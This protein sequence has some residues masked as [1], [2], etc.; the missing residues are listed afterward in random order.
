MQSPRKPDFENLL[1]VLRREAPSRP[2]LFEFIIDPNAM[3]PDLPVL[4]ESD[5]G[6]RLR[7]WIETYVAFPYDF[8]SLP[9]WLLNLLSF[10]KGER[11]H[12]ASISQNEGGLIVDEETFEAY[13]WPDPDAGDYDQVKD[14]AA[15][16]APGMKFVAFCP[17][18]VLEN[19]TEIVGFE[20][21]CFLLADEPELV[22]RIV[23]A[24]GQR[25]L[26]FYERL[27]EYPEVGACVV[28]DDWGFKTQTMLSPAQMREFIFPWHRRI[29]ALI[30]QAGRPAILHSCGNL[31]AVWDDL[32]DDLGY[33][34]KHSYEDSI[35]PIEEAYETYAERIALVG[36]IDM[37][38][39]C[40]SEPA[41]IYERGKAMLER[42]EGRGGYA[43]GSG[44]SIPNYVPAENYLALQRAV[45]E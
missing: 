22:H 37:D 33:D 32:I 5:Q 28:N 43:L 27:L 17:S 36:G 10:P 11:A 2:T 21:M 13:P 34:G 31:E 12:G 40:R 35:L 7:Q 1:A 44:N 15:S 19:L 24:I 39:L 41:A 16:L 8:A 14:A 3:R 29:V 6:G 23:D 25:L 9:F 30:H 38:F 26:R 42:V 20:D 4:P 18:G 45:L